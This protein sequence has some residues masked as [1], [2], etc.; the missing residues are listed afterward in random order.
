MTDSRPSGQRETQNCAA[1]VQQ[2]L[3]SANELEP[4]LGAFTAIDAELL[5]TQAEAL[6]RLPADQRGPLHGLLFAVKEVYD[7]EGYVCG[8]GTPIQSE[9]R[10]T[11]DAVSVA[12][13]REAGALV[14][15]ITVSTEYALGR[16]GPTSN[17]HDS[18]RTPGASSQGSA[19]AVGAG[20]VSAALG[21]QT[22]GSIIRPAAYCGCVGFKPTW[23]L[24]DAEGSMPLAQPIDHVG[25]ITNNPATMTEFLSKLQP[26]HCWR[27]EVAIPDVILLEP[28]YSEPTDRSVIK[29]LHAAAEKLAA[30]GAKVERVSLPPEIGDQEAEIVTTILSYGMALNHGGDFD[31]Q[32]KQMSGRI[33]GYIES[34]RLLSKDKYE[35]ALEKRE[36]IAKALDQLLGT[37]L[38]LAP[39][40]TGIAPQKRDGTGSRAPQRL[41]TLTGQPALTLPFGKDQGLPIGIQLVAARG[42]DSLVLAVA[43]A[44]FE[45]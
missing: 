6:D 21:S 23:G 28:W 22:I 37:K 12:R 31:R 30:L 18:T 8:W 9:R 17:P 44:L 5:K 7:V 15:G 39:A 34:G 19:A 43:N 10:P 35:A 26:T 3:T 32:G 14:A 45:D 33:R 25:I 42:A 11:K 2:F 38:F 41:W 1:S 13:L 40:T 36:S 16:T 4:S 24:I 27:S 20:L 29:A